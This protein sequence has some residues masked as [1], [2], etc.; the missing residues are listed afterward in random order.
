MIDAFWSVRMTS[1][2]ALL[3]PR[4]IFDNATQQ[5]NSAFDLDVRLLGEFE[6]NEAA[7]VPR[8]FDVNNPI[9]VVGNGKFDFGRKLVKQSAG[10]S[11]AC[12]AWAFNSNLRLG[13]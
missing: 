12:L 10:S 7:F 1:S 5:S 13:K 11:Q 6:P 9:V 2:T 8:G 4:A 3:M